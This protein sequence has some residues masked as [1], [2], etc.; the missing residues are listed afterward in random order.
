M[1][2]DLQAHV[3]E[4]ETAHRVPALL[5]AVADLQQMPSADATTRLRSAITGSIVLRRLST[6]QGLIAK[7]M[8]ADKVIRL[9]V[10][11]ALHI[12]D[13]QVGRAGLCDV[14]KGTCVATRSV[15][16]W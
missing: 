16:L 6:V 1:G 13:L 4:S 5:P 2:Q 8:A 15:F 3:Q 10:Y 11:P 12:V 14:R 9:T 7:H